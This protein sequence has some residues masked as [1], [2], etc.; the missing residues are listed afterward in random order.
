MAAISLPD[1]PGGYNLGNRVYAIENVLI[2]K[3]TVVLLALGEPQLLLATERPY[4]V[5]L[6]ALTF[7]VPHGLFHESLTLSADPDYKAHDGVAV[8]A[9]YSLGR[10]DGVTFN[11]HR[12]Y[13]QLLFWTQ[14][15]H[16]QPPLDIPKWRGHNSFRLSGGVPT[17]ETSPR[18]SW[19]YR[20]GVLLCVIIGGA[21][22]FSLDK[23][24]ECAET[25]YG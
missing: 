14:P 25:E 21:R 16:Y 23:S 5:N 8:Y 1:N 20:E 3:T 11:Q 10:S 7:Q 9:C 24:A 4:F 2:P 6:K 15:V 12:K 18:G 22:Q 13:H 17:W 19:L